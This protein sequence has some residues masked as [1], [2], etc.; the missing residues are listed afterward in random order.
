VTTDA[1]LSVVCTPCSIFKTNKTAVTHYSLL[2]T[3]TVTVGLQTV[4]VATGFY[5]T[6][7]PLIF[8]RQVP[9]NHALSGP[10][11]C[12]ADHALSAACTYTAPTVIDCSGSNSGGSG[13][14]TVMRATG[15]GRRNF[16]ACGTKARNDQTRSTMPC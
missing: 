12:F 3:G 9:V 8:H 15:S 16:R 14:F 2:A 5:A 10:L 4:L 13:S 6:E 11:L 1:F 7:N